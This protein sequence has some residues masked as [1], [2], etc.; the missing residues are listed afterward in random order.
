MNDNDDQTPFYLK[1]RYLIVFL[2]FLGYTNLYTMRVNLSVAIVALTENRT[3]TVNG[4]KTYEQQFS[5]TSKEKG[6][7]LG[8]FFYGYILTQI[9][10][11]I[12]AAKIGGHLVF[13][14]GIFATAIMGLLTPILCYQ[15]IT[16]LIAAR[17]LQG[18]FS[19]LSFPSVNAIYAK[20]SPPLERSRTASYGIS[21]IYVGTVIA[22][23]L[24]GWL[25]DTFGW[26]SIFYVFGFATIIWN[27]VWFAVVRESPEKDPW[28]T[29]SEKRFIK[30][31]LK[32]QKG[33]RNIIKPPWKAIFTSGPLYVIAVAHF[34]YTYGYY[35]LL[36]QLPMY[37]RDI[38]GLDLTKSG[39][40]SGVPYILQ[41]VLIF[42]SGYFADWLLM[43]KYFTLTQV[44]KYFN[45]S[46]LFFQM[47]FLL[48]SAF[49]TNTTTIIVCIS[50]SVGLGSLAMSGYLPNTI[51]I[52][53]QFG[54]ILLGIT[55][56]FATVSGLISPPLSGYIAVTPTAAEY[57]IIFFI[58]C[59][60][61]ILGIIVYGIFATA[62]VQPWAVVDAEDNEN[63]NE[64]KK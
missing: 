30:E 26:E 28:I 8:A 24:S 14:F 36:T 56:T 22:N 7:A 38:L 54:S 5:W 17:V 3:I 25:G 60:V 47:V 2:V 35:T 27:V 57:Q 51:D 39:I 23:L 44:R 64:L 4:T 18:I 13:G 37:M 9:P 52:A 1:K 41:T 40:V 55:N 59:G 33:Q 12:L 29:T 10:G 19:G 61:Y 49:V 45:N 62:E 50:F 15:G 11:G 34:S 32:N 43:K 16:Y 31:S 58:T 46:A 21:G 53:P 20:W 48:I 63:M 6:F 42:I